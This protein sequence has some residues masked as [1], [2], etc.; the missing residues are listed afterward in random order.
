MP[1]EIKRIEPQIYFVTWT[2]PLTMQEMVDASAKVEQDSLAA[3]E[4]YYIVITDFR[5]VK[6]IPF[7]IRQL[8]R[9]GTNPLVGMVMVKPPLVA[10][11]AA[12]FINK[13]V[14]NT[15]LMATPEW[16][17]AVVMARELLAKHGHKV[18]ALRS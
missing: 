11:F 2:P 13:V 14:P 3:G 9:L 8:R 16:D 12:D 10:Q 15:T 1:S 5:Q 6:T 17:D 7:D 4:S 18:G